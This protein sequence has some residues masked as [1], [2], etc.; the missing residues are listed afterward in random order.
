MGSEPPDEEVEDD[1][2]RVPGTARDEGAVELLLEEELSG[3]GA[4]A[5]GLAN[6]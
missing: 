5:V 4:F 1:E 2:E 3:C 6:T